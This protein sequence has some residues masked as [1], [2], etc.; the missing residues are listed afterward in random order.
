MKTREPE[1]IEEL[2]ASLLDVWTSALFRLQIRNTGDPRID[3]ALVCPACGKIHGRCFEAMYPF[4]HMASA[5]GDDM[6][7]EASIAL[8]DWAE[9]VVSQPDGSFLNDI[10]SPWKGTTVFNVIQMVDCLSFHGKV[11]PGSFVDRLSSRVRK[12]ADFLYGNENS[13]SA[14]ES[15]ARSGIRLTPGGG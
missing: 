4:L 7:V 2:C 12:A 10:D 3:G 9:A 14:T 1:T 15:Q 8:F 11:L 13:A 5:T 6:W